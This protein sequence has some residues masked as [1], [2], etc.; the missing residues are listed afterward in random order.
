MIEMPPALEAAWHTHGYYGSVSHNVKAIYQRYMGWFDGNPANLWKH[1]PVEAGAPL[2]RVPRRRRRGGRQGPG[3][4]S[5][6]ATCGSPP[7]CSTTPCSPTTRTRRRRE[8]LAERLRHARPR[9]RERH[10]AQLLPAWA[11]CE[12]RHGVEPAGSSTG[13]A[14]HDRGADRRAALR[15]DRHPR[16]RAEGVGRAPGHR[17]AFHRPRANATAPTLSNGALIHEA[18]PAPGT[19]RPH[20]H[21]HQAA[22]ARSAHRQRPTASSTRA[23]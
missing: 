23:T 1:P 3:A 11:R 19:G 13:V 16:R 18:D 7:S 4:T 15:L 17:L 14:G 5:T 6:T 10:L 8:L 20:A 21:A 9:R 22:A 12:L 2:R